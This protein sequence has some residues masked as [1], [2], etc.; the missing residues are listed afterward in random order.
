MTAASNARAGISPE[1]QTRIA[2]FAGYG[3]LLL[4]MTILGGSAISSLHRIEREEERIRS[5]YVR[6]SRAL[7][8]LR[9]NIY[10]SGT[11]MREYLLDPEDRFAGTRRAQFTE[12]RRLV[13]REIGEYESLVTPEAREAFDQLKDETAAY[14]AALA[15]V[16]QW[17]A[18]ERRTGGYGFM[19][20]ELLPR[21]TAILGLA[22]RVQ[23][24]CDRE[25]ERSSEAAGQ[26][27]ASVRARLVAL[28]ILTFLTGMAVA[29]I[30]LWRLLRLEGESRARFQE[31]LTAREELKKL[32][33]E[34]RSA[35][36][37]ERRRISRELHDEV[38][39]VLSAIS[40]SL[41]NVR[42]AFKTG[43]STGAFEQ[44]QVVQEMAER[45]LGVVRDIALLLRPTMLDDLGLLPALRWL[46]RSGAHDR[47]HHRRGG[48]WFPR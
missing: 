39:Q 1:R 48:G 44:L 29:G 19:Q 8:D 41:A 28:L 14:F 4:L 46:A 15:P 45:N 33:A 36:E 13:E 42:S 40:L 6:R 2:L 9:S 10:V 17:S 12:T 3:G 38:G 23:R 7:E 37:S 24:I 31:V 18:Q 11:R 22:D 5:E 34:L 25:L 20:T 26:M 43:H 16:L 30:S 21:R 27:V 35:Q 32:S 47:N